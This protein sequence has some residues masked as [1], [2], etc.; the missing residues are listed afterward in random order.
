MYARA[1]VSVNRIDYQSFEL[2]TQLTIDGK[3][4]TRSRDLLEN[5]T[6]Q[7]NF[8]ERRKKRQENNYQFFFFFL[9]S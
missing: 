5:V 2:K 9:T 8:D 4:T 7:A 3:R 1:C 6:N